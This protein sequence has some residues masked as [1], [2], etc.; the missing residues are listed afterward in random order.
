MAS[1]QVG[2]VM[3]EYNGEGS[4]VIMLHSLGGTSNA[5]Q[6]LL[7]PLAGFRVVKVDRTMPSLL[8]RCGRALPVRHHLCRDFP[9]PPPHSRA[10]RNSEAGGFRRTICV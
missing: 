8:L 4:P 1:V 2:G 3:I 7:C 5:F 9:G 10:A 6:P